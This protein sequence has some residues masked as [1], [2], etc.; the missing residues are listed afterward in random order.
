MNKLWNFNDKPIKIVGSCNDPYFCGKDVALILGY[1]NVKDALLKYVEDEDKKSLKEVDS[2]SES[3]YNEGKAVYITESGVYDLVLK[4]KLPSAKAFKRWITK[5][6]LPS[7]RKTGSYENEEL[8]NQLC[9]AM[10]A[11]SIKD[12]EIATKNAEI[13]ERKKI[14]LRLDHHIASISLRSKNEWIYVAT[15][16]QYAAQNFFKVGCTTRLKKRLASYQTGRPAQDKFYYCYKKKVH[17]GSKHEILIQHTLSQFKER[18]NREMYV[19]HFDDLVD[20]IDQISDGYENSEEYFQNWVK[21]RLKAS[22]IKPPKVPEPV[23]VDYS[24]D[25]ED[26]MGGTS[27]FRT[28]SLFKNKKRLAITNEST[29]INLEDLNIPER[30]ELI[31]TLLDGFKKDGRTEVSRTELLKNLTQKRKWFSVFK[32]NFGWRDSNTILDGFGLKIKY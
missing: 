13:E 11:L 4:S 21:N 22:L 1:S 27:T 26:T 17:N 15:T 32:E 5:E 28:A 18:N 3:T 7:I 30:V 10:K 2:K 29:T 23:E 16:R 9:E 19:M 14:S 25:L 20:L 31:K 8:K 24:E 12:D 6:V